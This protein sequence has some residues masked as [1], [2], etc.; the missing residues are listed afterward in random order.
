M[1]P[2]IVIL[3]NKDFQ[4]QVT[5]ITK[6]DR[7]PYR[8]WG[9]AAV[10]VTFDNGVMANEEVIIRPIML[11]IL[12]RSNVDYFLKDF[13]S[14]VFREFVLIELVNPHIL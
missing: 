12:F 10:N 8:R 2:D 3:V 9:E 1:L 11:K 7:I 4:N 6:Q 13:V 14:A 5:I